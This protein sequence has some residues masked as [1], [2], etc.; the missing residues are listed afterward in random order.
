MFVVP[1]AGVAHAAVVLHMRRMR[2]ER[3][4]ACCKLTVLVA[5][6]CERALAT[7]TAPWFASWVCPAPRRMLALVAVVCAGAEFGPHVTPPILA[8]TGPVRCAQDVW[9]AQHFVRLCA[10]SRLHALSP[11][12]LRQPLAGIMGVSSQV[13]GGR[14]MPLQCRSRCY[15]FLLAR[16]W[17]R[18]R[19]D[20]RA[21][22]GCAVGRRQLSVPPHG[23]RC[24]VQ[25]SIS[26]CMCR[27]DVSSVVK[28]PQA[29]PTPQT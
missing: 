14:P 21:C 19:R 20:R 7:H 1:M 28:V 8:W 26:L 27:P 23:V 4:P 9:C 5:F 22:V 3:V 17:P 18:L 11:A 2:R 29:R 24:V 25:P 15:L 6:A 16:T 13:D 10:C 12:R